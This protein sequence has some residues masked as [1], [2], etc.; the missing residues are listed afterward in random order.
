MLL[1][2]RDRRLGGLASEAD[3]AGFFLASDGKTNPYAELDATLAAFFDPPPTVK[4][5]PKDPRTQHPQCRF[6]A[7]YAWLHE[8]LRFDPRRLPEQPCPRFDEWRRTL[9]AASVTVI[10]ADAYVNSPASMYGHTFL[11]LERRGME[12][13]L[14]DYTVSF[15]ADATTDNVLLYAIYGLAGGFRGGFTTSPFY[16]KAQEY[17]NLE[18][19]D[20]WEYRLAFT[21]EQVDQLVRHA[22]EMGSTWFTYYFFDENCSYHLLALIEAADPTLRLRDAF[23]WRVVP[24]DTVRMLFSRPGL[25]RDVRY[26]PSHRNRMLARRALLA[27][28]EVAAADALIASPTSEGL[29]AIE[30]FAP[31]R[32]ARILDAAADYLRYR[33]GYHAQDSPE[34]RRGERL[35]LRRRGQLGV[36]TPDP[37]IRAPATRPDTGHR[38]LR[39]AIGGGITDARKSFEVA[40]MRFALHDLLDRPVGFAPDGQADMMA[41]HLRF[42]NEDREAFVDAFDGVRIVSLAPLDRWIRKLSWKAWFGEAIARELGCDGWPCAYF[43]GNAGVGA[44]ARLGPRR[45]LLAYGFVES[46]VGAGP[47]F[48]GG[49]RLGGGVTSGLVIAAG[50]RWR[51]QLEATGLGYPLGDRRPNVRLRAAQAL[52]LSRNADLRLIFSRQGEHD[53]ALLALG[54]YF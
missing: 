23:H 19:R 34:F 52:S 43:G 24:S 28:D 12:N 41:L 48:D 5:D 38:T 13:P 37:E 21:Q 15:G 49:W 11:R 27:A 39:A 14:L 54:G 47:A 35:L 31:P 22:W 46:D 30:G 44:A 9:D 6:P 17:E 4:E 16:M 51:A 10:F 20:L 7:R 50:T 45:A 29:R 25:V 3:G 1:H 53:E 33:E 42:A 40:S 8:R 18:S 32:Q 36:A 26:R 2:Y